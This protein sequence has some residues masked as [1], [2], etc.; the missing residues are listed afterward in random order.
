VL[1]R[2][3]KKKSVKDEKSY[4]SAEENKQLEDQ[5]VKQLKLKDMLKEDDNDN[6]KGS[7]EM[8]INEGEGEGDKGFH[9]ARV[10]YSNSYSNSNNSNN[11]NNNSKNI[12]ISEDMRI[13]SQV[14]V[15]V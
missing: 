2:A 1:A 4:P 10:S 13:D 3:E 15:D 7:V 5:L 12:R 14:N 6:D 11:N 8:M 9:V